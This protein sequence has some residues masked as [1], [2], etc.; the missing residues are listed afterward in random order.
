MNK[1]YS[2]ITLRYQSKNAVNDVVSG[3]QRKTQK[4]IYIRGLIKIELWYGQHNAL[5]KTTFEKAVSRGKSLLM[6]MYVCMCACMS[7]VQHDFVDISC[8]EQ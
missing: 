4:H 8:V 2:E 5:L 3:K 7:R 6:L 1:S